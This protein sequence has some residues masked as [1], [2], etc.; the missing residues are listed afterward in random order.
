[1]VSLVRL[2]RSDDTKA[3]TS[4]ILQFGKYSS[5]G[6]EAPKLK[7]LPPFLDCER[8][9]GVWRKARYPYYILYQCTS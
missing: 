3:L 2:R 1:M 6:I 7:G 5:F 4:M 9:S 8:L